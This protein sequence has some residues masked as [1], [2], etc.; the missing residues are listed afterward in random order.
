MDC[1]DEA[2]SSFDSKGEEEDPSKIAPYRR[3]HPARLGEEVSCWSCPKH[4]VFRFADRCIPKSKLPAPAWP[5]APTLLGTCRTSAHLKC[6]I[7]VLYSISITP[8]VDPPPHSE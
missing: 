1:P 6:A 7:R 3:L 4:S 5:S 2:T 8:L